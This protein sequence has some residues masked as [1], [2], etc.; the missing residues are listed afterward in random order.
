[1]PLKTVRLGQPDLNNVQGDVHY[2]KFP[3]ANFFVYHSPLSTIL[4]DGGT[5]YFSSLTQFRKD[6]DS[7][8][9]ALIITSSLRKCAGAKEIPHKREGGL[10]HLLM[11]SPFL[12]P[13]D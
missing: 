2:Y 12:K 3:K 8:L 11:K 10:R 9:F 7:T 6:L 1:M 4:R 13:G 5:S